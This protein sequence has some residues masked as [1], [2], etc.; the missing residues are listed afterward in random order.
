R[1]HDVDD[2]HHADQQAE[3]VEVDLRK[4]LRKTRDAEN[5]H[6]RRAEHG[7]DGLI[8]L[9][10]HDQ[11][12]GDQKNNNTENHDNTPLPGLKIDD[13]LQKQRLIDDS[14][15]FILL[16]HDIDL[17]V[18]QDR[19]GEN[20]LDQSGILVKSTIVGVHDLAHFRPGLDAEVL[21]ERIEKA[22]EAD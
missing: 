9:L 15:Q 10:R 8:H 3:H 20:D 1:A 21:F 11:R 6:G 12:I 19:D 7:G 5:D 13:P 18:L 2:H 16:I 22:D 17:R 14:Q 4:Q